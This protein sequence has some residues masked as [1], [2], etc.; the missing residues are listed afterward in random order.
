MD[1]IT[2]KKQSKD[3]I[4]NAEE[5]NAIELLF[6]RLLDDSGVYNELVLC[7]SRLIPIY[8][9]YQSNRVSY[10]DYHLERNKIL[11]TLMGLIDEIEHAHLKPIPKILKNLNEE[12]ANTELKLQAKVLDL[13]LETVDENLPEVNFYLFVRRAR[14]YKRYSNYSKAIAFFYKALQ[15][16]PENIEILT[17]L[18]ICYQKLGKYNKAVEYLHKVRENYPQDAYCINTLAICYREMED[19]PN[20]LS[21]LEKGLRLDTQNNYFHSNLFVIHLF[22]QKNKQAAAA[23]RD[24]YWMNNQ[25]YLIQNR[26]VRAD[27]DKFLD[28]FD[29]IQN[30]SADADLITKYL[31]QAIEYKAFRQPVEILKLLEQQGENSIEWANFIKKIPPQYLGDADSF[32]Y[33]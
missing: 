32:R 7:K 2:L 26:G 30:A 22:F 6:D 19:I 15:F 10:T 31:K 13:K 5:K 9:D 14:L 1:A 28:V 16:R 25:Q 33:S 17:D 27:F 18:A 23:V 4:G 8:K 24:N 21:I 20:A 29:T 12:L 3:F 11:A